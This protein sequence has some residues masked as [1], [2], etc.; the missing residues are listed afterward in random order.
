MTLK[1]LRISRG[2]QGLTKAK[3]NR[4]FLKI[5]NPFKIPRATPGTSASLKI[6]LT[7]VKKILFDFTSRLYH[8]LIN[9][10]VIQK[11][12]VKFE[13]LTIFLFIITKFLRKS[14]YFLVIKFQES[15]NSLISLAGLKSRKS[16]A[17]EYFRFRQYIKIISLQ[18]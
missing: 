12:K 6:S 13:V 17:E 11:Y 16:P 9:V 4:F 5:R 7:L 10:I 14:I 1:K 8:Y 15:S 3:N 2:I 18:S